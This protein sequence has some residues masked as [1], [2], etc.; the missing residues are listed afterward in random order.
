MTSEKSSTSPRFRLTYTKIDEKSVRII[1]E[2]AS[3]D[4]PES[5]RTYLE[6]KASKIK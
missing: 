4:A 3:P 2:M 1:F 6:G 5:F